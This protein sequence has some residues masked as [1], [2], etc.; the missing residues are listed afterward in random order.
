[1]EI[2]IILIVLVL[3]GVYLSTTW[4]FDLLGFLMIA[5]FGS[6]LLIHILFWLVASYEY[7]LFVEKRQAF[8]Q[9]LAN[10]REAER[11]Y[12]VAAI[13]KDVAEWNVKLA[14][15][16]HDNNFFLLDSYI[17]DRFEDLEPIK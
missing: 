2:L 12:E 3:I 14:R 10:A 7:E 9:T 6:Y 5:F 1:M 15:Q 17:D 8:E 4:D 16:K 13:I 11:E